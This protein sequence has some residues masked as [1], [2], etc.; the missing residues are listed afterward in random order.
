MHSDRTVGI[1]GGIDTDE[2]NPAGDRFIPCT[3]SVSMLRRRVENKI[4]LLEISHFPADLPVP[5]IGL[6]SEFISARELAVTSRAIEKLLAQ[7]NMRF[8]VVCPDRPDCEAA[9]SGLEKKYPDNLVLR[10]GW[11]ETLARLILA[12]ADF[13]LITAEHDPYGFAA[14]QAMRY[15]SVPIVGAVGGLADTVSEFLPGAGSGSGFLYRHFDAEAMLG[16]VNR[17]LGVFRMKPVF[18]ALMIANMGRDHSWP[19]VAGEYLRVYRDMS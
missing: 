12:G 9:F 4:R 13:R 7:G 8:L 1:S 11:D 5:L 15:G 3:Y 6:I 18:R 16:S 2:W 14:M 17:A 19:A 10:L